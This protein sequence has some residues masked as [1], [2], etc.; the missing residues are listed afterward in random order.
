MQT[1]IA[2][3]IAAIIGILVGFWLRGI[4]TKTEIESVK[5]GNDLLDRRTQ[6][7]GEELASVRSELAQAQAQ[8]LARAGFESLADERLRALAEK[9]AALNAANDQV[10]GRDA[11]ILRLSRQNSQLQTDL[12]NEQG[13]AER[14]TQQFKLLANDILKE[15]SKTFSEGSQRELKVRLEP[16]MSQIDDFRK[17]VEEAQ[18]ES[19]VGRTELSSELK[20]LKNLNER[21]TSEAHNLSTALRQDTQKQGFW[22]ERILLLI[23]E[24]S[25]FLHKGTHYSYQESFVET[26]EDGQADQSRRTDVV[27]KLPE[28][29]HLIIDSKVSIKDYIDS[30]TAESEEERLAAIKRHLESVRKHFK[31]LAAK[32]YTRLPGLQSPD[33]VVMFIPVEPAFMLAIQ[34]DESLWT[35]AYQSG[36]L[37]A[38]PTTVLFVIRIVENLWRQEQQAKNVQKV[39]DRGEKLYDKFVGFVEDLEAVGR[40]VS[41]ADQSYK[42]AFKKLTSDGGLV[43][44]VEMLRVLGL[45][46]KKR[47]KQKLLDAAGVDEAMPLLDATASSEESEPA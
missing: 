29:R 26:G 11:E 16:L 13:N 24:K 12:T 10:A 2:G 30:T 46:P 21:L 15:N 40:S 34:H 33:F 38:G 17:K 14:L 37:L 36:V 4:S 47:L 28:G 45:K 22:G 41:D 20:Q 31:G 23:L 44:Q 32:S 19:L 42:E 3:V 1:G 18:K 43:R 7:L 39:M 9:T 35:D 5:A 25:G 8:A 27:V 6:E